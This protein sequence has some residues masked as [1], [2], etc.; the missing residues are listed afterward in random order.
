MALRIACEILCQKQ[1]GQQGDEG[2][3]H[4]GWCPTFNPWDSQGGGRKLTPANCSLT[5]IYTVP[6]TCMLHTS[7]CPLHP[8]TYTHM[9]TAYAHTCTHTYCSKNKA[10]KTEHYLKEGNV[11]E[12]LRVPMRSRSYFPK[13]RILTICSLRRLIC[14][15]Y[16][17]ILGK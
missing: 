2:T 12:A 14:Q 9:H 4:L 7:T 6:H 1:I 11:K 10:N 15:R 13:V 16:L 17:Y 5:S 8:Y 3:C